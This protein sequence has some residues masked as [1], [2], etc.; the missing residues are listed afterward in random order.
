MYGQERRSWTQI[1]FVVSIVVVVFYCPF[2]GFCVESL[3][4]LMCVRPFVRHAF[5]A[6]LPNVWGGVGG[7]YRKK[8]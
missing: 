4:Y 8:F 6:R 3:T 1:H 2:R 7:G 5:G